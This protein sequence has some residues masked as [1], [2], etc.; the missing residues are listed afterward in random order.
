MAFLLSSQNVSQYLLDLDFCN[1]QD[2][3][4]I[5]IEKLPPAKNFNLLIGLPKERKLLIKQE[6]HAFNGR[7]A[8][9]LINEWKFYQLQQYLQ[10]FN[11][12]KPFVVPV[13]NFD[14]AHSIIIYNY[15]AEY[16]NLANFYQQ[17]KVFDSAIAT[18][19]GKI[20]ATLHQ[21]TF[22]QPNCQKFLAKFYQKNTHFEFSNPA[23][24]LEKSI[25]R[26]GP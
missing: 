13:L 20:L 24:L 6:C 14:E 16:S 17:K 3:E 22:N 9:E 25:S 19:V 7:V 26:I 5:Q 4:S 8:N 23:K 1:Q 11:R 10:D 21:T 18:A 12:L 15:L 2:L